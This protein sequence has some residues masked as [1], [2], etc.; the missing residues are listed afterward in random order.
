MSSASPSDLGHSEEENDKMKTTETVESVEDS[1]QLNNN[2]Q[3]NET[4]KYNT[5][6]NNATISNKTSMVINNLGTMNLNYNNNNN[7]A[8]TVNRNSVK[9]SSSVR[10]NA[11]TTNKNCTTGS[12]VGLVEEVTK[13]EITEINDVPARNGDIIKSNTLNVKSESNKVMHFVDEL[14]RCNTIN[15]PITDV[16]I[17]AHQELDRA[18]SVEFYGNKEINRRPSTTS[19]ESYGNKTLKKSSLNG[20]VEVISQSLYGV[21]ETGEDIYGSKD[22]LTQNAFS[23]ENGHNSMSETVEHIYDVTENHLI[24]EDN[25]YKEMN[26]QNTFNN[27]DRNGH[28]V[29]IKEQNLQNNLYGGKDMN[30]QNIY[31]GKELSKANGLT[32]S[33]NDINSANNIY[34]AP[35][36]DS[37]IDDGDKLTSADLDDNKLRLSLPNQPNT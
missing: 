36:L 12:V 31:G 22:K 24:K 3:S 27:R 7:N 26:G 10:S 18:S 19:V 5:I 23:K 30:G 29:S 16:K 32:R 35:S 34:V 28:I 14:N 4:A 20:S 33:L 2:L 13:I 25:I 21:K 11:S 9:N 15:G 8:S 6:N 1:D 17:G 37:G